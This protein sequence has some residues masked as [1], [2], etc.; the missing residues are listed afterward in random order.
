MDFERELGEEPADALPPAAGDPD[1][2][3]LV[4][5]HFES[6][7]GPVTMIYHEENSEFIHIDIHRFGPEPFGHYTLVTTGMAERAMNVPAEVVDREQYRFAELVLHLPA[8]WPMEWEVL[9]QT[10]N[11]WPMDVLRT[12]ARLPH[13]NE[14]WVWSGHT[15]RSADPPISYA[16]DTQ[17]CAAL[18]CPAYMIPPE[19]EVL[20]MP[21][22]REVVFHNLGFLYLEEWQFCKENGSAAFMELLA[23]EAVSPHEFFVLDK[24]RRNVCARKNWWRR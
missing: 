12:L 18:V 7:Y 3:D 8:D 5:L 16:E 24:K 22:G 17:L 2:I 1:L 20:E 4:P 19:L 15:I 6:V 21:D 13:Q 11:W 14:S 23:S 10:R 9:R